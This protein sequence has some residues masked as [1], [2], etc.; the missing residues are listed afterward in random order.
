MTSYPDLDA[1]SSA[2]AARGHATQLP[3]TDPRRSAATASL[4]AR[5]RPLA[6]AAETASPAAHPPGDTEAGTM[7]GPRHLSATERVAQLRSEALRFG[8]YQTAELSDLE[9]PSGEVESTLREQT[10]IRD[11]YMGLLTAVRPQEE[12]V[13]QATVAAFKEQA[14]SYA[15]HQVAQHM[16]H[17]YEVTYRASN[18]PAR[19]TE[20]Q[21]EA[22]RSAAVTAQGLL[23]QDEPPREWIDPGGARQ[24]LR[25]IG[26]VVGVLDGSEG[27]TGA[28]ALAQIKA[29]LDHDPLPDLFT[30]ADRG[31]PPRAQQPRPPFAAGPGWEPVHLAL[32]A[33]QTEPGEAH[34]KAYPLGTDWYLDLWSADGTLLAYGTAAT[35][36]VGALAPA[37]TARAPGWAAA[38]GDDY[39]WRRFTNTARELQRPGAGDER[40]AAATPA[41]RRI[42]RRNHP[43]AP[44]AAARPA[45]PGDACSPAGATRPL[46]TAHQQGDLCQSTWTQTP[47]ASTPT[48]SPRPSGNSSPRPGSSRP[49]SPAC[50]YPPPAHPSTQCSPSSTPSTSS[51]VR[52]TTSPLEAPSPTPSTAE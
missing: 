27:L 7:T 35:D 31:R 25:M 20:Q 52:A 14:D 45:G 28:E 9:L 4:S 1:A 8:D 49:N 41:P 5:T 44:D 18:L 17:F 23:Q 43:A 6:T 50:G 36:E 46:T 39:A 22:I 42:S 48:P 34:V 24:T 30:L 40:V 21:I 13:R 11:R 16:K 32:W 10:E 3:S 29:A 26:H 37:L 2:W 51:S 47:T 33:Y 12:A 19:P 38:R 15:Q